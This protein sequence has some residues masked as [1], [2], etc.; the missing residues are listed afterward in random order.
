MLGIVGV[1]AC[2]GGSSGGDSDPTPTSAT[3]APSGL[4]ATATSSNTI[5]L[6][7]T[8]NST[9]ETYFVVERSATSGSGFQTVTTLDADTT[10]FNN[11]AL[12]AS[13]TYYYRVYATKGG[14]NS[15]FSNEAFATTDPSPAQAPF[16]PTSLGASA[17]SSS[18][19]DLSWTDNS[20]DETNFVVER[21]ATSGSAFRTIAIL[22]VNT[23]SYADMTGLSASTTYYYRVY[24]TNG[25]GSPGFSNEASATTDAPPGSTIPTAPTGL[26][27]TAISSSSIDLGWTDNSTNETNYVIQRS[28]TSSSGFTTIATLGTN[29][30]SYAD[31]TGLSASTTYYYQ[32]YATNSAGSS[33]FSNE[34]SAITDPAPLTPPIA[35]SGLGATAISSSSIS[36]S[37]TDNSSDESNFVV[38]RSTTS[39]SGFTTIATLGAN[40][41]S[42]ADTAGL[43]AS[44][45][46][47]Y[48]VYATNSTG[49]SGFSNEA[50][51]TTNPSIQVSWNA[52]LA[53]AVNRPGGGYK[54][55]YS[56]NSGFNPGDGGVTEIDVPYSSGVLAPTSVVIS[57]SPGTYYIRIV[58]YSALN[59]PGTS[60]GS[61]STVT[62]QITLTA[63]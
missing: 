39:G 10:T 54:V 36:L 25:V 33:G 41:T 20:T 27:A 38:Q 16:A 43:S 32:V 23:T 59:T 18:S 29:T 15:S 21:S 30:T 26:G 46:Y 12:N 24:A 6:S 45:T 60:G 55:Y 53:T 9:D 31:T 58:A 48:Q 56:T 7:W 62:P 51:S 63:P 50:F 61:T 5:R 52:S 19:I 14:G 13:T 22:G 2:G 42:Y 40:T 57:V 44:T 11:S 1:V 37:W 34:A 17:T 49:D 3:V 28:T 35:P 8:D 47:Y 4:S